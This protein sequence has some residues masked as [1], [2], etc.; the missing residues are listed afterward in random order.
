MSYKSY[1]L[2][3]KCVGRNR[4]CWFVEKLLLDQ[5]II[6]VSQVGGGSCGYRYTMWYHQKVDVN[7]GKH[8]SQCGS[9]SFNPGAIFLKRQWTVPSVQSPHR[10]AQIV[11]IWFLEHDFEFHLP[12]WSHNSSEFNPIDH[13]ERHVTMHP[14]LPLAATTA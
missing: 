12:S 3:N 10:K 5:C 4:I 1:F 2:L 8:E 9:V 7:C 6:V 13:L 11:S 14:I